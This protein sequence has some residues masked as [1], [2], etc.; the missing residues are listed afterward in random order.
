MF[1]KLHYQPSDPMIILRY[2]IQK[3]RRPK[4][5]HTHHK[6][7][8]LQPPFVTPHRTGDTRQRFTFTSRY[9][10]MQ[11]LCPPYILHNNRTLFSPY[12]ILARKPISKVDKKKTALTCDPEHGSLS[13]I[14]HGSTMDF[15]LGSLV[16]GQVP[17]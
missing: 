1:L 5:H 16:S 13:R 15:P 4:Y 7:A 8:P 17:G 12:S 9:E 11:P 3:K 6:S 10:L 14:Q 2:H